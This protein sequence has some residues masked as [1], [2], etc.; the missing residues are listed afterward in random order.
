[1]KDVLGFEKFRACLVIAKFWLPKLGKP[2]FWPLFGLLPKITGT[3]H[4]S[5]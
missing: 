4:L 2:S 1:M 3:L 5:C